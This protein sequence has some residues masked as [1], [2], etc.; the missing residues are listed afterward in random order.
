MIR[1]YKFKNKTYY[2]IQLSYTDNKG[3]RHQRKY[4]FNKAGERISSE[5]F[6]GKLEFEYLAEYKSNLKDQFSSMTFEEWHK[7]YLKSISLSH[8]KGT[9]SQYDGDLKK[10]L[11]KSFVSKKLSE[12][13]KADIN[14]YIFNYLPS[15]GASPHLQRKK[16]KVLSRIFE[17][18]LEEGHIAKNPCLGITVK[19]PPSEKL[20]L[21]T[22]EVNLFLSTAREI[23]HKFYY[24][25]A[26]SLL[27]GLRNGE[28][29]SLRWKDIDEETNLITVSSQ[30]T[31]KD[32]LH[33]T[34]SNKNRN[35]PIS[36]NLKVLLLELKNMGPFKENL[37]GLN[38]S[39]HFIDD[40][41]LPRSSEWKHGEQSKIT[42]RFCKS[43]NITEVKFHDLRATFI[44]NLLSCGVSSPK[45]MSIVG[46]TRT[47]TIDVYLR[48]AGV[49]I[50]GVTEELGYSLPISKIQNVVDIYAI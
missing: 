32:G 25:W 34:K 12:I 27:T 21:N 46:H 20:V 1:K 42:K 43:I 11:F 39:S 24:L 38:K 9:I 49:N 18:A 33:S 48:L 10:W 5:R 2:K 28:L 40:L 14:E 17:A 47:S 19:V 29:Y 35:V 36:K 4:S 31:N 45:V 13:S 22:K 41:V 30:W 3:K 26:M 37:K 50:K 15:R 8:T 6:A 44:T 16:G 7:A 23:E